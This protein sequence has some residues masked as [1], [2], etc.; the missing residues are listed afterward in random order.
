MTVFNN[1]KL[2][3]GIKTLSEGVKSDLGPASAII[4]TISQ[5]GNLGQFIPP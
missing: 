2:H 3:F 5:A 4:Q 1:M